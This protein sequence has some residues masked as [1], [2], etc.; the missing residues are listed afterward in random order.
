MLSVILSVLHCIS[1]LVILVILSRKVTLSVPSDH[2]IA[3][4]ITCMQWL[5]VNNFDVKMSKMQ[6]GY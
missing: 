3:G 4:S 6:L 1:V 5:G 2:E